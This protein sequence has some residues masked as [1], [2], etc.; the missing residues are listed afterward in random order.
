MT[1]IAVTAV[2][3]LLGTLALFAH[4]PE[5]YRRSG[6]SYDVPDVILEDQHGAPVALRTV[7]GADG[8]V[9]LQFIFTTCSTICP[10]LSATLSAAQELDHVRLISITID[11]ENDTPE[12]IGE[13]A[14]R[15]QAGGRWVFLTGKLQDVATVQRAFDAWRVNK[16]RHSPLTFLRASAAGPWVRLDGFPSVADLLREYRRLAA[17]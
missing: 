17:Q 5:R 6:G 16:M 12:R 9:L 13:Y 11:P 1:R 14:R 15:F 3:S 2:M 8:P 4:A 7:L 10:V